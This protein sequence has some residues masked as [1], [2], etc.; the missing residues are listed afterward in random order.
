MPSL[1]KIAIIFCLWCSESHLHKK[2]VVKTKVIAW[3]IVRAASIGGNEGFL[4]AVESGNILICIASFMLRSRWILSALMVQTLQA[5]SENK[6]LI[7]PRLL[8]LGLGSTQLPPYCGVW[9]TGRSSLCGG[10]LWCWWERQQ[11]ALWRRQ[12]CLQCWIYRLPEPGERAAEICAQA[13]II[14]WQCISNTSRLMGLT[15]SDAFISNNK[16]FIPVSVLS[17]DPREFLLFFLLGTTESSV[18]NK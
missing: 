17:A 4:Q 5:L 12:S 7:T 13:Q 11:L 6:A 1:L 15:L 16:Y 2:W 3:H 10:H 14:A 8:D 9:G 18:W